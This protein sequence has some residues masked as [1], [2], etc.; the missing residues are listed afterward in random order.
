MLYGFF[1]Y[2]NILYNVGL[3]DSTKEF[4]V[5]IV[6]VSKFIMDKFR[7]YVTGVKVFIAT[8]Y[9]MPKLSLKTVMG[10]VMMMALK[11]VINNTLL[12]T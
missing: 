6:Y 2:L 10:D 3:G 11:G 12:L 4:L 8:C 1:I 9:L 7:R 5:V